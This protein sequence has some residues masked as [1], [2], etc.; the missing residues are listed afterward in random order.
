VSEIAPA[1]A[2][3]REIA[4]AG[5][6]YFYAVLYWYAEDRPSRR[7]ANGNGMPCE[8]VCSASEIADT[9]DRRGR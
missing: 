4:H 5:D 3:C 9:W 7:D 6:P 8:T 1:A 2:M